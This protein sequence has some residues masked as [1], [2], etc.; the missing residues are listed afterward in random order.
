MD[1]QIHLSDA[2]FTEILLGTESTSTQAHLRVCSRCT[3]EA[4]HVAG[5]VGDFK[6]QSKLWAERRS[7]THVPVTAHRNRESSWSRRPQAWTAAALV[8]LLA[9]G[10]GLT[11][12]KEHPSPPSSG[13]AQTRKLTSVSPAT[14]KADN[15]LL[16]AID[17][18]LQADDSTSVSAYMPSANS[19]TNRTKA[20]KRTTSE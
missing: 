1:D 11:I 14:L 19:Q 12:H 7:A 10:A 15:D 16:T 4:A 20:V 17:G 3:E 5:A 18:E 2:Q 6:S 8:A 9:V 13:V